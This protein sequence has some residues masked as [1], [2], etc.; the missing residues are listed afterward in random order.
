MYNSKRMYLKVLVVLAVVLMGYV[1]VSKF[2]IRNDTTIGAD[3]NYPTFWG[4]QVD[5]DTNTVPAMASV[6]VCWTNDINLINLT[7]PLAYRQAESN[8]WTIVEY[9]SNARIY[10]SGITNI[11]EYTVANTDEID[12]GNVRHWW[13]GRQTWCRHHHYW[14]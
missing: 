5:V 14:R 13:V 8:D 4:I 3:S 2:M 1:A 10:T 7:T 6:K 9:P 12:W 11:L